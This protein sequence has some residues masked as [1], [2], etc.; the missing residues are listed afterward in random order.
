MRKILTGIL[1]FLSLS[2]LCVKVNAATLTYDENTEKMGIILKCMMKH[3]VYIQQG[4][5]IMYQ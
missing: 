4:I 3:T 5:L 1:A 2:L